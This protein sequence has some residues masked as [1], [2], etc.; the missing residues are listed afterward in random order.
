MAR[1]WSPQTWSRPVRWSAVVLSCA[2]LPLV[3]ILG[4]PAWHLWNV[5]QRDHGALPEIPSGFTNDASRL[6]LTKVHRVWDIPHEVE[7]AEQQ[8]AEL[9]AVARREGLPVSIA[10]ARHSMGGHTIAPDGIVVNMRPFCR[11]RLNDAKDRL[12]VQA[13]ALWEEIVPYLDERGCS[14]AVMQSNASFS[15]GGSLSVNCHGWQFDRPPIAA[16][17]ES[18]RL[19]KFDGS[20]VTCS[21]TLNEELFSLVLGGYGLLGVILDVELHVV[22]NARYR[23][24]QYL[25]PTD[26]ALE[27]YDLRIKGRPDVEMA[28][29]RLNIVPNPLFREVL[30]TA[31]IREDGEIPKLHDP[32]YARLQRAIFRGSA[33][34]AYGKQLRWAA[35]TKLQPWLAEKWVSRNQL[36][37]ES[38]AVLQNRST[39]T[40]D[41]LHEYFLPRSGVV[42]FVNEMRSVITRYRSNLLNVTIRSVNEDRDS[43]L[44]YADQPVIA[45]VLLFEQPMTREAEAQMQDLTRELIEAALARGGRY[46]LPYRLHA[47]VEQFH[48]AY[49]QAHIFFDRKR[50]HDP[51]ELFQ[52]QFYRRYGRAS[53]VDE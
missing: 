15:V 42:D 34:N 10:G 9:L 52:N 3:F 45:F 23:M 16:T 37:N 32:D 22:P 43:F 27:T 47:T 46:Y 14:V 50:Q 21:R 25:V 4:R 13:G 38:V 20:I 19:M 26:E 48:R 40:T 6:N 51:E 44:R 5:V 39:V 30:L 8:L 12:H 17:V 53:A 24:E 31:F 18:F 29:A 28:Y 36:L 41:I 35:E 11:M 49:P 33:D 2:A 1:T 7:Q